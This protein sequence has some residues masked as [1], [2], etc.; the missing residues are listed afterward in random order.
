MAS[1][2]SVNTNA[3]QRLQEKKLELEQLMHRQPIIQ[4]NGME[5]AILPELQLALRDVFDKSKATLQT[6]HNKIENN[7]TLDIDA[8]EALENDIHQALITLSK[9]EANAINEAYVRSKDIVDLQKTLAAEKATPE[10]TLTPPIEP[11]ETPTATPASSTPEEPAL[12][13]TARNVVNNLLAFMPKA[14]P[15]PPKKIPPTS[16]EGS[17]SPSA[18]AFRRTFNQ[19]MMLFKPADE[20]PNAALATSTDEPQPEPEATHVM[21]RKKVRRLNS[22]EIEPLTPKTL[23]K[24]T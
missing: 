17:L 18:E 11:A 12:L 7:P 13:V 21:T 1:T 16:K 9:T 3:S 20:L 5:D 23:T 4:N 6:L 10:R 24:A 2:R 8:M 22:N 14:P 19:K 15:E